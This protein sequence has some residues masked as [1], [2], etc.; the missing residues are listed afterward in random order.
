MLIISYLYWYQF[1]FH[2]FVYQHTSF[3]SIPKEASTF[4]WWWNKSLDMLLPYTSTCL[5]VFLRYF[6]LG[7][8]W[9]FFVLI[10]FLLLWLMIDELTLVY[11][12]PKFN[13]K[14]IILWVP[15]LLDLNELNQSMN[16]LRPIKYPCPIKPK[17]FWFG[18]KIF[19]PWVW[20]C[21]H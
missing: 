8:L 7:L 2:L 13:H 11:S 5:Q 10:N 17:T 20:V 21:V 6:F 4:L 19:R 9:H 15:L 18:P 1:R 12:A 16:N 3:H 14:H